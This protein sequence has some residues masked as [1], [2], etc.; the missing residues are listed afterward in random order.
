MTFGLVKFLHHI[1]IPPTPGAEPHKMAMALGCQGLSRVCD[2]E[3]TCTVS[4]L[5]HADFG[6]AVL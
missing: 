1:W 6:E 2:H 5:L 3:Y 4:H